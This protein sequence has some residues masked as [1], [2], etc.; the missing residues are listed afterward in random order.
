VAAPNPNQ[1]QCERAPSDHL[2]SAFA[3]LSPVTGCKDI[4]AHQAPSVFSLWEAWEQE[5][6]FPC[7][8][9]FW[10]VVWPAA[11]VLARYLL[12]HQSIVTG[13]KVLEI[14]CGGGVVSI[15]AA[16][17]GAAK[18]IANDIDPVAISVAQRNFR[19]NGVTVELSANDLAEE[20]HALPVDLLC[21][22]DMFYNKSVAEKLEGYLHKVRLAGA[23]VLIADGGR[24][25]VPKHGIAVIYQE[26][27][28][29]SYE[30]EGISQREVKILRLD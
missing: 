1:R 13:K 26:T 20:E 10:A 5:T 22:A 24:P 18:V 25:F 27:V 6:G 19:A 15:A 21:I 8:P 23:T 11:E 12:C 7:D 9:P 14:G 17:A 16:R 28:P 3:P 2:L 4:I 29:V 30:V